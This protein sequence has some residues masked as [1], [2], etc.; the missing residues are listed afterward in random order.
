[1]LD[2]DGNPP[3]AICC[4]KLHLASADNPIN[5]LFTMEEELLLGSQALVTLRPHSAQ[6]VR[7]TLANFAF[8]LGP[9]N[10]SAMTL[11]NGGTP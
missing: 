11:W 2:S 10:I 7:A 4:I 6:V 8:F 5:Q 9:T 1:V 3:R